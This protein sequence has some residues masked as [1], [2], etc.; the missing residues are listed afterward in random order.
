MDFA[1]YY[2]NK[3]TFS[4][5]NDPR[6]GKFHKIIDDVSPKVILDVGCGNGYFLKQIQ[7]KH[8]EIELTGV[9]AYQTRIKGL[10]IK[11]ADITEG[12]PFKSSSFDCVILG[13]VIEHVPNTDFLLREIK[14]VL[15]KKG[16]LII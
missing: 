10:S 5:I 6:F 2:K 1:K 16:I 8:P 9:D 11:S 15:K 13:E 12:L 14:R 3:Q 4:T 7:K